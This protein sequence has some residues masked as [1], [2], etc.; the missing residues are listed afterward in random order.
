MGGSPDKSVTPVFIWIVTVLIMSYLFANLLR[1]GSRIPTK[2]P[3]YRIVL[4]L[5]IIGML[6]PVAT[7]IGL[8]LLFK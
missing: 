6:F 4:G 2:F 8:S 3:F 1:D 5:W 7:A